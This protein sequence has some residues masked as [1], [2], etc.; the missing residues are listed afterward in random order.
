MTN[1]NDKPIYN[2]GI[3]TGESQRDLDFNLARES[4]NCFAIIKATEGKNYINPHFSRH[5]KEAKQNSFL[6]APY[7]Y[8]RASVS[9]FEQAKFFLDTVLSRTENDW[10]YG[11]LKWAIDVEYNYVPIWI[12]GVEVDLYHD[13]KILPPH[14][15]ANGIKTMVDIIKRETGVAP[16]IYT[17]QYMWEA[18]VNPRGAEDVWASNLDLWVASW[19]DDFPVLPNTWRQTNSYV[20]WQTGI[21]NIG[22]IDVDANRFNGENIFDYA[23]LLH[24]N[25]TK[26]ISGDI[27]DKRESWQRY[28]ALKDEQLRR[29]EE[30]RD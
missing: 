6:R 2:K 12:N 1:P 22:G 4:G 28:A 16:M 11:E 14:V 5:W 26:G 7:H 9:A 23:Q 20:F 27:E 19:R 10:K 30:G 24:I 3:D 21:K 8:F 29:Y 15:W 18:F 25:R 17:S 13:D